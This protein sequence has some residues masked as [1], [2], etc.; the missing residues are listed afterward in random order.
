MPL[1][2]ETSFS[3][4]FSAVPQYGW[5]PVVP[6]PAAPLADGTAP[7]GT[8]VVASSSTMAPMKLVFKGVDWTVTHTCWSQANPAWEVT[9]RNER[10]EDEEQ[11]EER[12][13]HAQRPPKPPPQG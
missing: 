9:T 12:L 1:P 11:V 3:I 4:W 5:E 2:F 13:R 10:H 7:A 6:T 8:Q